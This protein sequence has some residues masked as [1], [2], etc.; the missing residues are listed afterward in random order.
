MNKKYDRFGN[1][2]KIFWKQHKNFNSLEI[3]W[4]KKYFKENW[5]PKSVYSKEILIK[6]VLNSK[7]TSKTISI[8]G[9]LHHGKSTLIEV[10]AS[11][12]HL[13]NNKFLLNTFS[14]LFFLEQETGLTLYP[15][16]VTLNLHFKKKKTAI[17]NFIDCPGHPDFQDQVISCLQISEGVVLIVDLAEGVMLGTEI[18][19]KNTINR[20]LPLILILNSLDRL[21]IE[22]N[23][24]P[25]E[26]HLR[27]L[28]LLDEINNLIQKIL[29]IEDNNKKNHF[30][31]FNPLL[32]NVCF[33]SLIQGWTF[34]IEQFSEIYLSSQPSCCLSTR[35]LGSIIWN[36]LLINRQFVDEST[37]FLNSKKKLLFQELI[38]HPI[39]KL[40]F[41]NLTENYSNIRK[42]MEIELGI[43]GIKMKETTLFP[44]KISN[45]CV[46]LFLGG[47]RDLKLMYNHSGLINSLGYHLSCKEKEKSIFFRKD[48]KLIRNEL[49]GYISKFFPEKKP[50]ETWA[51]CKIFNGQL[52]TGDKV[53]VLT[54]GPFFYKNQRCISISKIIH[55]GISVG[56]Y[57]IKIF[58]AKKGNIIITKGLE[59]HSQKNG[60]FIALNDFSS[61]YIFFLPSIK[62]NLINNKIEKI[63]KISIKPFEIKDLKMLIKVF[64]YLSKIYPNLN[65]KLNSYG[66]LLISSASQFYIECILKNL[67][68]FLFLG[69]FQITDP[70][71]SLKESFSKN[72]KLDYTIDKCL[73]LKIKKS[74]LQFCYNF[75]NSGFLKIY[76]R[77]NIKI[78]K[79]QFLVYSLT[80][81][82]IGLKLI[83]NKI[84]N[85][86]DA[87]NLWFFHLNSINSENTYLKGSS[88]LT[89]SKKEKEVILNEIKIFLRKGNLEP[90][91]SNGLELELKQNDLEF[92]NFNMNF[93]KK[94]NKKIRKDFSK[95]NSLVQQPSFLI[96][97]IFPENYFSIVIKYLRVKMAIITSFDSCF[98][99]K[100]TCIRAQLSG[101]MY[102][103]TNEEISL[104]T[105]GKSYFFSLFDTWKNIP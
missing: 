51:L 6:K 63:I 43:V 99:K 25:S 95:L 70:Y 66:N 81:G 32:N 30:K 22:L 72:R 13:I 53:Q 97:V 64:R 9:H 17:F 18:S 104:L 28:V 54:N 101:N 57:I 41:F 79:E 74:E 45:L 85:K 2:K 75:S 8:T 48:N 58:V 83:K 14:D 39:F 69:N 89:I 52:K 84:F 33:S 42:L 11:S 1:K 78:R 19:L 4:K 77:I 23:L 46:L 3:S 49:I 38:L 103:K 26:I 15:N 40:I 34:T 98:S 73:I 102:I 12:V 71:I 76:E 35:E 21:I 59:N 5:V 55:L 82:H 37:E 50:N 16:V 92:S 90:A 67:K 93:L 7:N 61:N 56:R 86:I 44:E 36:G 27:I 80:G 10:L 29:K 31:Y 96:E 65:C 88:G 94:N 105:Q 62:R 87:N 60:I 24:S 91:F 68:N 20:G 100:T 47:V